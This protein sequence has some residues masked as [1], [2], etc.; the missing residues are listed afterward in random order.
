MMLL[1]LM[2]RNTNTLPSSI[3]IRNLVVLAVRIIPFF[4]GWEVGIHAADSGLTGQKCVLLTSMD[5]FPDPLNV[6]LESGDWVCIT[7][8][9]SGC[10]NGSVVSQE[11]HYR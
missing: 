1:G 8:A 7:G 4:H 11:E 2:T 9:W 6:V 5:S 10:C 3:L